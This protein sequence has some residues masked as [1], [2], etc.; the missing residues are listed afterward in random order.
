MSNISILKE[1][2]PNNIQAVKIAE[3]ETLQRLINAYLRETKNFDPRISHG[4]PIPTKDS[5]TESQ[6]QIYFPYTN[7]QI[8]GTMI[9]WS[10]GGH[11]TYGDSF[12]LIQESDNITLSFE[13]IISLLIEEIA[14][15]EKDATLK[16]ENRKRFSSFLKNSLA[17]LTKYARFG[18]EEKKPLSEGIDFRVSEQSLLYG[19]PFHPTPKSSEG[20]SLE[21]SRNYSPEMGASF[22]LHYF[23]IAPELTLEEWL[24]EQPNQAQNVF[25]PK[26]IETQAHQH[27]NREQ[28]AYSLLPCHP[29]QAKYLLS[30]PLIQQLVEEG[31]IVDLGL[32]GEVVY[33]TSSV[34][35]VW[36]PEHSCFYKLSLHIRITNF[37]RE[38]TREQLYRTFDA[39]KVV[40]AVRN[41]YTSDSFKILLENGFRTVSIPAST[42]DENEKVIA[43]FSAILREAPV[44]CQ[45]KNKSPYV[46]ASL[47]EVPPNET[48]P[49]LFH[50]I[51][52]GNQNQ[53]PDFLQWLKQYLLISM[54]PIL[55][56][57][58][59]TGISLEAHIQNSML[60]LENG[61]PSTFYIR[62]LEGISV[63]RS[64][65]D[66]Q[67]WVGTLISEESPVLYSFEQAWLRL[68]YYFF[69]NHLG[70]LVQTLAYHTAQSE[71]PYWQVVREVLQ[72]IKQTD[73]STKLHTLIDDLLENPTL[74]AKANLFSYFQKR[75]ENPLYV[76]IPNPIQNTLK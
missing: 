74:P 49:I 42:I 25:I 32:L 53:L 30:Q 55:Q 48:E 19:H 62:D 11:H 35:T 65:A 43:S 54:K 50:A 21:D 75:G 34:R 73:S 67:N 9:H 28:Q 31:K 64:E 8:L 45:D 66:R 24:S 58:A 59:E 14:S 63:D 71:Y 61:Y 40:Q 23:A 5:H 12:S 6:I 39:S 70:H 20:F 37:I 18:M 4:S 69:V 2:Q 7:K 15:S 1:K 68:K 46:I 17:N 29:W 60:S 47:F 38:N 52:Q 22:Q 51:R 10:A 27:L 72:S 33:P 3:R 44:E 13:E 36:S 41:D 16:E 57:Y 56:F 76:E 26:E